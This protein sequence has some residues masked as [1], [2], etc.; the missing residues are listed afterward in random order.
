MV[1]RD[2]VAQLFDD[3]VD[4]LLSVSLRLLELGEDVVL[5]ARLLHP[6]GGETE[7]EAKVE[8]ED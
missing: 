1:L 5:P 3:G 2:E 7:E 8:N 4:E 6:G